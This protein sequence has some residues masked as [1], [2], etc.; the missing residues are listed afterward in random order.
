MVSVVCFAFVQAAMLEDERFD[1]M[2][3]SFAQQCNGIEPLLDT[4]FSFLRRKTD[5]FTGA[6]PEQAKATIMKVGH[7]TTPLGIQ[8]YRLHIVARERMADGGDHATCDGRGRSAHASLT[9]RAREPTHTHT[10][11]RPRWRLVR[12][13]GPVPSLARA[14][15]PRAQVLDKH[16]S[17]AERTEAAKLTKREKEEL[18]AKA[19]REAAARK[20]AEADAK[21]TAKLKK[22][23]D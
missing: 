18:K 3:L 4:V 20:Q 17:L 23:S 1:G 7:L 15:A 2:L 6:S 5:F 14:A 11:R 19:A 16:Q 10:H 12:A 9:S 21:E 8:M 13:A 22:A